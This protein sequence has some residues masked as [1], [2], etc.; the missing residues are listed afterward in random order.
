MKDCIVACPHER[1]IIMGIAEHVKW[2][3]ECGSITQV[4]MFG[5]EPYE[6]RWSPWTPPSHPEKGAGGC[7]H[8]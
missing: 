3:P 5:G 4:V 6:E 2:C 7:S 1:A 8:S